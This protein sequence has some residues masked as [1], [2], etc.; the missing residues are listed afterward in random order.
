MFGLLL[1]Q[2]YTV[3][4]RNKHPPESIV[5]SESISDPLIVTMKCQGRLQIPPKTVIY[6]NY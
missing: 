2:T 1:R 6:M 3:K 4:F 5:Y